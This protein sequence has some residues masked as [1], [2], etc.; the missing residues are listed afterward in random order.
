MRHW[1]FYIA[2]TRACFLLSFD[3][4]SLGTAQA[5]PNIIFVDT[6]P[7]TVPLTNDGLLLTSVVVQNRGT[8][9]GGVQF[10]TFLNQSSECVHNIQI[11]KGGDQLNSQQVSD[12]SLRI[13]GIQAPTSGYLGLLT[14]D[15]N[16]K[17]LVITFRQLKV[18]VPF[19]PAIAWIP[20]WIGVVIAILLC[21]YSSWRLANA[22]PPISLVTKM[23]SPA[24]DFSK[25]WASN[26]TV[27]GALLSSTLGV[28]ALP[29]LTQH[30]SKGGYAI[31]SV[32]FTLL[33]IVAPLLFNVMRKPVITD[34]TGSDGSKLQY[35]GYVASFLTASGITVW[36]VTGQML[37]LL[38]LIDEFSAPGLGS[39]VLTGFF[40][41]FLVILALGV[42]LYAAITVFWTAKSQK[43]AKEDSLASIA[44]LRGVSVT[45]IRDLE[46][47]LPNW[48]LL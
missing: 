20:I 25:S 40:Q 34:T 4:V 17:Q 22:K 10:C 5:E 48:A 28:S 30:L 24:W 44:D 12:M 13:T 9:L 6:Q 16:G 37:T 27:A 23:G 31:L 39:K 1:L 42:V 18:N 26:I 45:T 41:A 43:I 46:T 38:I 29:E 2:L 11:L 33:V 14:R 32:Y 15:A 21:L 8:G 3:Q 35:Q 47:P 19:F 36:A 7:L